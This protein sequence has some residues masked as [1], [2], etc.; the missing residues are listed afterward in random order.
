MLTRRSSSH[1]ATAASQ[2]ASACPTTVIACSFFRDIVDKPIGASAMDFGE[3]YLP[4][5]GAASHRLWPPRRSCPGHNDIKVSARTEKLVLESVPEHARNNAF[6]SR[7]EG[8][9]WPSTFLVALANSS[10]TSTATSSEWQSAKAANK[11]SQ[12]APSSVV[13]S[14]L[15]RSST[16][17]P[18]YNASPRL[19]TELRLSNA[20]SILL[21]PFCVS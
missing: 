21:P 12:T 14:D 5:V 19:P 10:I 3:E 6:R 8:M 7:L 15:T 13:A 11:A 18:N 4:A 9:Y 16:P 1:S 20:V 2:P 17:R